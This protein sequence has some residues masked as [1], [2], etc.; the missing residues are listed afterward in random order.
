[1]L[2]PADSAPVA[3]RLA[4]MA[5][6]AGGAGHADMRL[7]LRLEPFKTAYVIIFGLDIL[8]RDY[9]FLPQAYNHNA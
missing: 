9:L 5:V 3:G 4:H 6:A 7:F 1:M 2:D 8:V